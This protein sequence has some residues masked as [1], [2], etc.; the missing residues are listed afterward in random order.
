MCFKELLKVN[1][2]N[3]IKK[4]WNF[5][6]RCISELN[7]A[8][9]FEMYGLGDKLT[10]IFNKQYKEYIVTCLYFCEKP[11]VLEELNYESLIMTIVNHLTKR[12]LVNA[13]LNLK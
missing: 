12:V 3:F 10:I 9:V 6:K 13:H 8:E 2:M 4:I 7:N 1:F 5:C 11:V